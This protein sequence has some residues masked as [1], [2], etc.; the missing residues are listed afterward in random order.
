M[1]VNTD[2]TISLSLID[3]IGSK[4]SHEKSVNLLWAAMLIGESVNTSSFVSNALNCVLAYNTIPE[5]QKIALYLEWQKVNPNNNPAL[6][7]E[8]TNTVNTLY[9]HIVKGRN[10][11]GKTKEHII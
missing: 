4:I 6:L 2:I 7:E 10:T 11:K 5:K 1:K 3:K 9:A 8:L